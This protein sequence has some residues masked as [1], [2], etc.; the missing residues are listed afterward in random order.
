MKIIAP[1]SFHLINEFV[2]VDGVLYRIENI[3]SSSFR[4]NQNRL[5]EINIQVVL[6]KRMIPG[7][8]KLFYVHL[9]PGIHAGFERTLWK[10]RKC[11]I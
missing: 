4:L 10:V 2:L 9:G 1:L 8:L 6:P 5:I 11:C 7:K 3:S